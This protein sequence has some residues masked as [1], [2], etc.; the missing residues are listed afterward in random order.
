[1]L[2]SVAIRG[3]RVR[4]ERDFVSRYSV[5]DKLWTEISNGADTCSTE[6]RILSSQ[7]SIP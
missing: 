2:P 6:K 3:G 5:V 4:Y 7:I 1:M